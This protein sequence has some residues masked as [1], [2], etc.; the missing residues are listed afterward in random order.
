MNPKYDRQVRLKEIGPDGQL[1]IQASNVLLRRASNEKDDLVFWFARE[2][3]ERAGIAAIESNTEV[4]RIVGD[5]EIPS[6]SS[7]ENSFTFDVSR[8][9]AEGSSRALALLRRIISSPT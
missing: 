4:D 9:I 8:G 6:R 5:G 3:L 7:I 2:Y 1:R